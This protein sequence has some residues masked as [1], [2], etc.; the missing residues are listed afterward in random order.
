MRNPN[1]PRTRG[2][3]ES[4]IDQIDA[5]VYPVRPTRG[6]NRGYRDEYFRP[7]GSSIVIQG[8]GTPTVYR[9]D[10]YPQ[11][12]RGN[13]FITDSPTNL[14]H[15]LTI[16]DDGT[17]HLSAKNTWPRGEFFASSDERCR[18]VN[19][20]SAPDGNMYIVDMY[21]GVVQ[22]GG[23][24]SEYLTEYITT[25]ELLLPVAKGRIWRVVDGAAA[26]RRGPA[27]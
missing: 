5:T 7:D 9:G 11:A 20:F 25:Q 12:V 26:A 6:V 17:G 18:P 22:A 14:V 13:V 15:Q 19:L 1:S 23:I 2:L 8:A 4:L 27:P 24:W 16:V 21:R 10:R 3:Y